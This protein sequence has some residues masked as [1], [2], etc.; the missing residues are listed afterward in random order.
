[1]ND[2]KCTVYNQANIV[3]YIEIQL[4]DIYVRPNR[5]TNIKYEPC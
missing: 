2:E 5:N 3:S 4:K 1:M